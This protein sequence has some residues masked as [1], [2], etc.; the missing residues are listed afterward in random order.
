[1]YNQSF[2]GYFFIL[3]LQ[4]IVFCSFVAVLSIYHYFT[5]VLRK[6]NKIPPAV[7]EFPQPVVELVEW[8]T[9]DSEGS[10]LN[11][12]AWFYFSNRNQFSITSGQG[13]WGP[14]P[15]TVKW[16]RKSPIQ[17]SLQLGRWTATTIQKTTIIKKKK[18]TSTKFTWTEPRDISACQIFNKTFICYKNQQHKEKS[19][20]NAHNWDSHFQ[21]HVRKSPK[22]LHRTP[23]SSHGPQDLHGTPSSHGRQLSLT[24]LQ[25]LPA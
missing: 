18:A 22:V 15:C 8:R 5:H 3:W 20:L 10:G 14:M 24:W 12:R 16:V 4:L 21:F 7:V 19:T 1:M 23:P 2:L 25:V 17:W 11:P 13:R 9:A 6:I